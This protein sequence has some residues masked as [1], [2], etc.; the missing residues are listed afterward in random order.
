[1]LAD[2]YGLHHRV[3]SR[4]RWLELLISPVQSP[5]L[6][7]GHVTGHLLALEWQLHNPVASRGLVAG[8]DD[9]QGGPAVG[10]PGVGQGAPVHIIIDKARHLTLM[11]A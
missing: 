8:K 10:A 11:R 9:L 7:T 2:S 5:P 1:M 6:R 4:Q 3:C